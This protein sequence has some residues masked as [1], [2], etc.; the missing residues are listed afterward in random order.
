MSYG[1][2]SS[3]GAQFPPKKRSLHLQTHRDGLPPR[4]LQR[5]RLGR[6]PERR[7]QFS[8]PWFLELSRPRPPHHVEITSCSPTLR[9]IVHA[10]TTRAQRP[11]PR[12]QQCCGRDTH[13][14]NHAVTSHNDKTMPTQVPPGRQRHP[15]MAP[16]H[17]FSSKYLGRH[18]QPRIGHRG[19]ATKPEGLFTNSGPMGPALNRP[20]RVYAQHTAAPLQRQTARPPLRGRRLPTSTRRGLAP[21]K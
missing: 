1:E 12:G 5:V 14:A 20:L 11:S 16:L 18:I 2:T 4:R 21:R 8:S 7:P 6:H 9:R 10:Q 17:P 19:L 3:G 15:R 13:E